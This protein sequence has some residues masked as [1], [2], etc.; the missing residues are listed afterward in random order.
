MI[1]YQ[2]INKK[3]GVELVP[4]L[5]PVGSVIWL[6]GLGADGHDFLPIVPEMQLPDTLPLRFVFPHAPVRP[7]TINNG[8]AMRAWFD[9]YSMNIVE[10]IDEQGMADSVRIVENLIDNERHL[11]IAPEQIV[12]AGF[13]QGST[14][15]LMTGLT[16]TKRLAGV[17]ALSGFLPNAPQLIK[18][19]NPGN[20]QLPLFIAHGSEDN[21]IP[22][23]LGRAT[24]DVLSAAG[25]TVSWHEYAMPHSVCPQEIKAISAWLSSIYHRS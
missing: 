6:H 7:V 5:S 1:T 15:A 3:E 10:R 11:G 16:A 14:I 4:S 24:A 8:F 13:S 20:H 19:A 2:K 17:I 12:L 21:V 23:L 25:Y 18:N 22:C 9:I